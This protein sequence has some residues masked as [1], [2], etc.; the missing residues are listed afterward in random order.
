MLYLS[1]F[2]VDGLIVSGAAALIL[3]VTAAINPR[4]LL[5]DGVGYQVWL[6]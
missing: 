3:R 2:L 1:K 4:L 6:L 5:V